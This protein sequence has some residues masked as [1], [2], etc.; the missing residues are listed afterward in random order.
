[1]QTNAL[2]GQKLF[3]IAHDVSCSKLLRG[4]ERQ[5]AFAAEQFLQT[6][7]AGT[8][9]AP[10]DTWGDPIAQLTTVA[11]SFQPVFVAD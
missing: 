8:A 7:V 2:V 4:R 1:M 6:P 11:P 9:P 3:Q 10:D 5:A